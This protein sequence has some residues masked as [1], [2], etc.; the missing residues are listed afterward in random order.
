MDLRRA[1]SPTGPAIARISL[2]LACILAGMVLVTALRS[3]TSRTY[4]YG[5]GLK[6]ALVGF[7]VLL[8][9]VVLAGRLKWTEWPFGQDML[10]RFHKA[11]ALFA[12]LLLLSHPLLL[13]WGSGHWWLLYGLDLPWNVM[14]GKVVLLIVWI[15]WVVSQFRATVRLEFQRWRWTHNILALFILLLA[16]VHSYVTGGD[17]AMP[18]MRV[19][20]PAGLCVIM[21][22][23]LYHKVLR[24]WWMKRHRY[25]VSKVVGETSTVT[26]VCLT[27]PA[28]LRPA[29]HWPGQFHYVNFHRPRPGLPTEEHHWTISSAPRAAGEVCS[30]IKAVG[31]FTA[32]IPKT[33]VGDT[34]EVLGPFGRFSYILYPWENDLVF[35]AGGIGITPLMSMIRHM[36][37]TASSRRVL[38]IYA[39]RTQADIVFGEELERIAVS[40]RPRLTVLHVL[41]KPKDPWPGPRGHI[42]EAFLRDR[43]RPREESFYLCV[44]DGMYGSLLKALHDM[45]VPRGAIHFERFRL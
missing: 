17:L 43:C 5:L 4:V 44:P 8:L 16:F 31:D 21:A 19:I 41:S 35:I 3:G 38:L 9:Q 7:S 28:P 2:Y 26:T 45:K 25:Q 34:A 42:D 14:L 18:A 23:Y 36:H 12:S 39:N 32:T 20:W 15:Q 29:A 11:M 30:T 22:V 1:Q 37:D 13:S 6:A 40:G 27:P 24:S 10:L 33:R